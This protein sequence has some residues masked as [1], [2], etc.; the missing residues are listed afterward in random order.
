MKQELRREVADL[1]RLEQQAQVEAQVLREELNR[2]GVQ[3][4]ASA[5]LDEKIKLLREVWQSVQFFLC[6][7][8]GMILL[9]S[10]YPLTL[11]LS[12]T[13]SNVVKFT[14]LSSWHLDVS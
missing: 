7:W 10:V 13:K 3:S 8:H 9:N 2:T 11:K 4:A 6:N 5:K 14:I 1:R 12:K